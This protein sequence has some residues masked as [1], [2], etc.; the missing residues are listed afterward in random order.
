MRW[1]GP[2]VICVCKNIRIW[3]VV[4]RI[5]SCEFELYAPHFLICLLMSESIISSAAKMN[6]QLDKKRYRSLL[7]ATCL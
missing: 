6:C 2:M 4:R 1:M 7:K 5:Y 3:M